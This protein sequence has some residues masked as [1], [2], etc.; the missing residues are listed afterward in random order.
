MAVVLA[1]FVTWLA[2]DTSRR[3]EQLISFGGVCAFILL[4]FLLSAH[5][6]AVSFA[7]SISSCCHYLWL[8]LLRPGI[9]LALVP[10]VIFPIIVGLSRTASLS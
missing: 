10:P 7:L 5:R 9:S 1:L 6:T 2:L 4:L 8:L 3:P